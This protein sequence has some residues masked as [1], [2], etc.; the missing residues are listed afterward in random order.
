MNTLGSYQCKC[1]EGYQLVGGTN[2]KRCKLV[3]KISSTSTSNKISSTSTS[4]NGICISI[5]RPLNGFMRCTRRKTH[6]K[7]PIGTK[8]KLKCR[9]GFVPSGY[10]KKKCTDRGN[11]VGTDATCEDETARVTT[12]ARYTTT[13][14]PS[15]CPALSTLNHGKIQPSLCTGHPVHRHVPDKTVCNFECNSGYKLMGRQSLTCHGRDRH[16]KWK[17]PAPTC[18]ANFPEP[19]IMCP[20][21]IQKSLSGTSSSVYVMFPQPKTNVDWFRYVDS[22][23]TWAKQLEGE[24]TRGKHVIT[25]NAK[26][27]VVGPQGSY[28]SASCQMIVH[29]KDIE[30]PRA[31]NCPASF[32]THLDVGT[33]K[34]RVE[35]K[36]P[37]FYDNVKIQHVTASFLPGHVFGEGVHNVLYIATDADGNKVRRVFHS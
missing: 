27:P 13:L 26:S 14:E 19:F 18:M 4:K 8:C 9:N 7:F 22:I 17:Y 15:F 24:M 10:M 3:H 34:K 25:F 20:P 11:W 29:V 31:Q 12:T 21:D 37:V 33:K 5:P 35:W 16:P 2:G 36:E 1:P 30:P 6:G 32:S 23:P 28:P